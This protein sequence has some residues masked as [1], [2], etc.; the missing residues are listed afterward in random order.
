MTLR[1]GP[2]G[3]LTTVDA[4]TLRHATWNHVPPQP[5]ERAAPHDAA[6]NAPDPH[7][8]ARAC[9]QSLSDAVGGL[10]HASPANR[11]ISLMAKGRVAA[12]IS[13]AVWLIC[14]SPSLTAVDLSGLVKQLCCDS[15]PNSIVCA[16]AS[17]VRCGGPQLRSLV[18]VA[19]DMPIARLR[20]PFVH[21]PAPDAHDDD[22]L[23]S[24]W[25]R[26]PPLSDQANR[27]VDVTF[28]FEGTGLSAADLLLMCNVGGDLSHV[29]ELLL[30]S[31]HFSDHGLITLLDELPH[32]LANGDSAADGPYG[33]DPSGMI[34]AKMRWIAL[35]DCL[36]GNAGIQ[37]FA[38]AVSS[39]A[40]ALLEQI[41][42]VGNRIGDAGVGALMDAAVED[43]VLSS[44]AHL[45][46]GGNEI[47]D[48]GVARVAEALSQGALPKLLHLSFANNSAIGDEAAVA[49]A[50]VAFDKGC[51][52]RLK[53]LGLGGNR[54]GDVGAAALAS[55]MISKLRTFADGFDYEEGMLS[56]L[57][58][59]WIADNARITDKGAHSLACAF[60]SHRSLREVFVQGLS[61]S[62]DGCRAFI[63]AM[64]HLPDLIRCVVGR[65]SPEN[66]NRMQ[67][68]QSQLR[69]EHGRVD[70]SL[71]GWPQRDT[72][73]PERPPRPR[74]PSLTGL[75]SRVASSVRY[76]T[77]LP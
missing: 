12:Q 60:Q 26:G 68:L 9:L 29:E 19:S 34:L 75:R 13:A 35:N 15:W 30:S 54:V 42:L 63:E 50:N 48:V 20:A 37:R 66:L 8:D 11:T 3:V 7:S 61:V 69:I 1:P 47:T 36:I 22:G 71:I 43:S 45:N 72:P 58:G 24:L 77:F 70:I 17:A 41:C 74:T 18:L 40:F 28:N 14:H 53:Y 33:S 5:P 49:L 65:A 67:E 64:P 51:K 6:D 31:N 57:L 4:R 10:T 32:A 44:L 59:L 27:H 16:I 56:G 46:V 25:W 76:T 21:A 52:A 23:H 38:R 62:Q 39:G 2:H 73:I 55:A